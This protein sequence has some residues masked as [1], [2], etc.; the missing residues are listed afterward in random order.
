M[1]IIVQ[2][3][4]IILRRSGGEAVTTWAQRG[5]VA[6]ITRLQGVTRRPGGEAVTTRAQRGEVVE[7]TRLQ[8][9]TRRPG[10]LVT[11]IMMPGLGAV[12]T[13]RWGS[14]AVA[15]RTQGGKVM[16][17]IRQQGLTRRLG[18]VATIGNP[19]EAGG[20][21]RKRV[22]AGADVRKL[23]EARVELR[24]LCDTGAS[25]WKLVEAG[26]DIWRP[27]HEVTGIRRPGLT[28]TVVMMPGLEVAHI[29]RLG[30]EAVTARIQGGEVLVTKSNVEVEVRVVQRRLYECVTLWR[31]G[32]RLIIFLGGTWWRGRC[33][34]HH[35]HFPD[36]PGQ[37]NTRE[38][39]KGAF[40]LGPL[41]IWDR[42]EL[43]IILR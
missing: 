38:H 31:P 18:G 6:E 37:G 39:K 34:G 40:I 5:E 42:Q 4:G 22:E 15:T 25:I 20:N 43:T 21:I 35:R 8:V 36:R 24:G 16:D 13:R 14:E 28:V 7:I 23:V 3:P 17:I 41:V 27:G 10:D 1:A 32:R 29:G 11:D 12:T 19:V 33:R 9:V 30:L 26:A 2:R